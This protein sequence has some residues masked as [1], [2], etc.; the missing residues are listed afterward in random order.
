MIHHKEGAILVGVD[1]SPNAAIAAAWAT[2]IGRRT[3]SPVKAVVACTHLPPPHMH[4]IDEPASEMQARIANVATQSLIDA[5]LTGIEVIA[6]RG[7]VSEALLD[8]AEDWNASMLVV[9]TRGLGPLSGLLLGSISRRLLFTTHR[10]L[11]VVP[12]R[13]T[14]NPRALARVLIGVDC[15]TVARRV[16]SWS[17]AFCANLGVP[18]TIVRCADPGCEKPPG[19]VAR[20]DD[21]VRA[22]AEEALGSFRDH[23]VDYTI[24]VAHCD[25][26]AA[27][28][29][30]AASDLAGLIVVGRRGEGQFRGLGGTASYLVRHSPIPLAV[31][32]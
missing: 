13:S 23:D 30:T 1:G 17:V 5:G 27:L 10:P 4:G 20:V 32:P 12:R 15:S 21:Q 26:R 24:V 3:N 25:P 2:A 11:V 6:V 16:L 8:T 7:P 28:L 29:E 9:G 18:A 31:I 19:H 22:D 14:P